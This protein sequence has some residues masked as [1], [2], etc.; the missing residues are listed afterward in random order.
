MLRRSRADDHG[1][2]GIV[3]S[4]SQSL[5]CDDDQQR[6]Y[7]LY[8]EEIVV[9]RALC[10]RRS[11]ICFLFLGSWT[12]YQDSLVSSLDCEVGIASGNEIDL[13]TVRIAWLL[14]S[15]STIFQ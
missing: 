3:V 2:F 4:F 9:R 5:T 11:C 1:L 14:L 7:G 10:A 15:D 8:V 6:P 12:P 13:A